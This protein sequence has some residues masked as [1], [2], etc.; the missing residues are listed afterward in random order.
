[1][2]CLCAKPN[3]KKH[4]SDGINLQDY[5][6]VANQNVQL[7]L[8]V[9]D[10]KIEIIIDT[11]RIQE[12]EKNQENNKIPN[13][14]ALDTSRNI[15]RNHSDQEVIDKD[16][17]AGRWCYQS[18]DALKNFESNLNKEIEFH[19]STG[20]PQYDFQL[21]ERQVSAKFKEN[22]LLLDGEVYPLHRYSLRFP[23]YIYRAEDGT[24]RPVPEYLEEIIES[25]NDNYVTF[26][27]SKA[28]IDYENH[29]IIKRDSMI[30][31]TFRAANEQMIPE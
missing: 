3:R 2:G 18:P 5:E 4:K 24:E 14:E 7:E 21:N 23:K 20:E 15:I 22:L 8:S 31:M 9:H 11:P 28:Q 26:N 6:E 13:E 30:C 29:K 25:K 19:Y 10:P 17:P 27:G 1:M 16:N 12:I